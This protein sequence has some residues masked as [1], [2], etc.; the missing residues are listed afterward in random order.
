MYLDFLYHAWFLLEHF[1]P[2][3]LLSC[4][5]LLSFLPL[6]HLLPS[7]PPQRGKGKGGE[8]RNARVFKGEVR[9]QA[10]QVKPRLSA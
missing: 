1:C 2:S 10:C 9:N 7:P 4:L 3:T 8:Q 6:N 5:S